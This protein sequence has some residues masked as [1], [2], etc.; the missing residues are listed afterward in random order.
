MIS[1]GMNI[2]SKAALG[3][4]FSAVLSGARGAEPAQNFEFF[5]AKVRP[6]LTDHCYKCH[7]TESEKIKGGLLLDSKEGLLRGGDS[8]IVLVPGEPDKSKIIVAVRHTDKDLQMPP[9]EKL[10]GQE[11]ADLEEWVRMGAPDPRV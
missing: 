7:S 6:I 5:E 8:G 1:A 10:S 9:K 4:V 3:L 11:I 2:L